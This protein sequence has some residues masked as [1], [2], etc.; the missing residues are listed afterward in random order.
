MRANDYHVS[1]LGSSDADNVSG[2]TTVDDKRRGS[3][4]TRD[5]HLMTDV[6]RELRIVC[7]EPILAG[8]GGGPRRGSRRASRARG[9]HRSL[10]Q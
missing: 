10:G 7:V 6:R 9:A 3:N 1:E 8:H 4:R 5:L 2:G